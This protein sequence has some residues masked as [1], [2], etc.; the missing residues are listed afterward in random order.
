MIVFIR[1]KAVN[2]TV[3]EG[4]GPWVRKNGMGAVI[5][6]DRKVIKAIA[7]LIMECFIEVL[8]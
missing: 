1:G 7:V 4:R 3:A 2:D 8:L 5:N 6:K